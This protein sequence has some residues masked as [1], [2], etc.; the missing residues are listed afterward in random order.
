[1]ELKGNELLDKG[2]VNYDKVVSKIYQ[3]QFIN[4]F[5][6]YGHMLALFVRGYL[7]TDGKL[8]SLKAIKKELE[9]LKSRK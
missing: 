3:N 2:E 5:T 9:F 4:N 8:F 7:F 6:G 1:M